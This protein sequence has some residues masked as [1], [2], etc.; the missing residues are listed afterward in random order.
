MFE[1]SYPLAG[2]RGAEYNPRVIS[3]AALVALERSLHT[4]GVAKPIIINGDLIVAG[5]QRT[6]ALRRLGVTHA[7]VCV[8]PAG[9]TQADE[10]RFNQLHNGV[11]FDLGDEAAD[12]GPCE[13]AGFVEVAGASIRGNGQAKGANVRAE[14]CSLLNRYGNWG[15]CVALQS[16]PVI[17]GAQY[18][19]AC[20]ILNIPARVFRVPDETQ[21]EAQELLNGRYGQ[22]NYEHLP[23][24][25]FVQSFA[26]PFRLREGAEVANQSALYDGYVLP[27]LQPGERVLDFGCGQADYVNRLKRQGVDIIGVEFFARQGN[28]IAPGLVNRMID[29]LCHALRTHGRFDVVIADSVLNSVDTLQAEGDVL[30]CLHA[31]TRPGGR[32]Y[33][34]GRGRARFENR[35]KTRTHSVKNGEK[36]VIF[37]DDDGFSGVFHHG[38]WF[39]QKFCT[40][41]QVAALVQRHFAGSPAIVKC[42]TDRWRVVVTKEAEIDATIA[43]EALE[44]EFDLPWPKGRRVGRSADILAAYAASMDLAPRIP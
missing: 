39:Y 19:L 38:N 1:P 26:Q 22:F 21:A 20:M 29:Q 36:A 31:L 10:I 14:I 33:F 28:A 27:A 42:G 30:N 17:H 7:P 37:M 24:A 32:I 35:N 40:P 25:S 5:H 16:G 23:R 44:R 2:L 34:S 15:A 12:V 9:L 8:L 11:D 13:A 6:Q 43:L 18:A 4:I 3:P 41:A